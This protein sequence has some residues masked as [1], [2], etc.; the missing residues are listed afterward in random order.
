LGAIKTAPDEWPERERAY[1]K[2]VF[3][4]QSAVVSGHF[5]AGPRLK[6]AKKPQ[7]A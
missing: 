4:S 2:K 1:R 6:L 5:F 7:I 3:G